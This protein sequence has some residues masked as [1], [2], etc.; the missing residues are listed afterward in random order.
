MTLDA[1]SL[2]WA[3]NFVVRHSDGDL[4]PRGLETEAVQSLSDDFVRLVEQ[5]DLSNFPA[6][7]HRRFI[8]P[9]DEISYRAATQL[10]PQDSIILSAI[11]RQF[12]Q[13]IERRRMPKDKV[14]SYRLDSASPTEL[15]SNRASWND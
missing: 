7:A 1:A 2:R 9:K 4:F 5:K 15:Y 11:I 14:F 10:D 8:V 3:L 6:G 13:L 12:G